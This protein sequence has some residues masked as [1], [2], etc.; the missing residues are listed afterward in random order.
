MY[1]I[2]KQFC[3]Q[4]DYF[5]NVKIPQIQCYRKSVLQKVLEF[6]RWESST[7]KLMEGESSSSLYFM[8]KIANRSI[9]G[10]TDGQVFGL[11]LPAGGSVSQYSDWN[12]GGGMGHSTYSSHLDSH[13]DFNMSGTKMQSLPL[14]SYSCR[15]LFL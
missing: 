3:G 13:C 6:A 11:V 14:S 1:Q 10:W 2:L 12:G 5:E 15:A 7:I 9:A 8:C 4:K